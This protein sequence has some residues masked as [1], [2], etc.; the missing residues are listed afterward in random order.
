MSNATAIFTQA[1]NPIEHLSPVTI[2]IYAGVVF[3][4]SA[5]DVL[6]SSRRDIAHLMK[7]PGLSQDSARATHIFD[8]EFIFIFA[9]RLADKF[10]Q[11]CNKLS[12]KLL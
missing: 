5:N 6:V 10:N 4:F 7:S 8:L 1:L 12:I 3:S 11:A 2:V 9:E